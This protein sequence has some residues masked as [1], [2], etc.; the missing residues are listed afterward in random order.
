MKVSHLNDGFQDELLVRL[1]LVLG[2][3]GFAILLSLGF[4]D[5]ASLLGNGGG[6]GPVLGMIESVVDRLAVLLH[7]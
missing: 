3:A 5:E 7:R 6:L 1:D 2:L 4:S